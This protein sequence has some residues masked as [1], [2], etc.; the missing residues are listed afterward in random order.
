MYYID[1]ILPKPL[2]QTFTYSVNEDEARF[3]RPGMRVAVPFGRNKIYT[4]I[5]YTVHRQAPSGYET[6]DIHQILDE[7]PVVTATQLKHWDWLASYYMCSM[8]EVMRAALPSALLLE[9]ETLV[10][11]KDDAQVDPSRL[12]DD[13]FTL[14][15]ALEQQPVLHINDV[16]SI[17]DR[18]TVIGLING[19]MEKGLVEIEEKVAERYTPKMV[20]FLRL[21][22]DLKS[23]EKLSQVLDSLERAPKQKELM[24]HFFTMRTQQTKPISVAALKN[25]SGISGSIVRAL[26]DKGILQEFHLR[27]DRIEVKQTGETALKELSPAQHKAIEQIKK[28]FSDQPICLFHGVTSSGKTEIY[29]RLIREKM[30]QGK[31]VLYMLPEIALTAQLITRLRQYFGGAVSVYHSKYSQNERVEVWNNVR[32]GKQKAQVVL[33]ARSSMFLPFKDLG[34]VIIDESHEASFKQYSPS[35]R[36]HGRDAALVLASYFKANVL[37]GSATPSL[38]SFYNARQH[39]YGYVTLSSRYGNIMPPE[40]EL[41][42]LREKYRKK[43]MNGHISDTLQLAMEEAFEAGQ[44]VILF[45][46]RRGYAPV[47]SCT[48][49]GTI[50]QCPNC[51]VSLTY[52]QKKSQLRCHY[53]GHHIPAPQSCVACG[54]ETLDYKGFGTEQIEA[55]VKELFPEKTIRRMDQDSMRGKHAYER[56]IEAVE[57]LEVDVVVGTQMV[58]KGLD[59]RNMGLVGVMNADNLLNFPDF[60][61]HERSFQLLQQVAGRSGRT[62]RRGKVLV[63]TFSPEHP[64]LQQVVNND[65]EGMYE[66]ELRQ[67]NE[68]KYPPYFRLIEIKLKH[69]KYD[70]L[71]QSARWLAAL[72][73]QRLGDLVLGPEAPPVARVR[74]EFITNILIKIDRGEAVG[75]SKAYIDR[76]RRSFQAVKE[77]SGVKLSIDVDKF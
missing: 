43:R 58:A 28:A 2:R 13:E 8:G 46:N 76:C 17:L 54:M 62:D 14:I 65:Y 31:Q 66:A 33:G 24:L 52:H 36:Y 27:R 51:D 61:A 6:K 59:F 7:V 67:R 25:R 26:I 29:A 4:A 70:R 74:N 48:T 9:S 56:L 1:V 64:V 39:K 53:C 71:Q 30:A 73:R 22:P 69:R 11:L 35:P 40:I 42:D 63:Q 37:L 34:L 15:E 49:C 23:D 45:Q 77:F 5:V 57:N 75:N 60:R 10:K 72:L 55:E 18:Q 19:L 32:E 16:R 20:R 47:V 44:Q 21:H 41:V 12:N 3:L 68:F 38:E 50:P